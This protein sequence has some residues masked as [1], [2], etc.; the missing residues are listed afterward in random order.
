[1]GLAAI[2]VGIGLYFGLRSRAVGTDVPAPPPEVEVVALPQRISTPTG[3]MQLIPAGESIFGNSAEESPNPEQVV[4][5]D[6]FY[7]DITEVSNAAYKLFCDGAGHPYPPAPDWDADYFLGKPDYPVLNVSFQDAQAY[8]RWANKRLATEEEWEAAARG[9]QGFQL[10][11][12]NT[13]EEGRSNTDG[14]VDGFAQTAPVNA[15]A[16]GASPYGIL[17]MSGNVWEL[18]ASPYPATAKE[19]A[20]MRQALGTDLDSNWVVAKGGSFV[21]LIKD[22]DLRSFM[23][24]G[25]PDSAKSPYIGFRCAKDAK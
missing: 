9:R 12:G 1:M 23:R 5:L 10:P 7:L 17:N 14:S 3:A 15:F 24:A 25:F 8:A 21:S 11:W 16:A 2:V 22:I 4:Q 20:D 13:A 6:N 19:I 18:T